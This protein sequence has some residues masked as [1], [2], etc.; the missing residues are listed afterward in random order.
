MQSIGIVF[1]QKEMCLVSLREGLSKV[2]LD[3]YNIVPFLD[4][5]EEDKESAI[6]SNLE[7]FL[8]TR[9]SARDNIFIALPRDTALIRFINLPIA[10]EENLRQSI[11]YELDRHTPFSADEAYFDYHV[12]KRIPESGLL[13]IMLVTIKKDQLDYYIQ[14]L[15]KIKIKPRNIEITTTALLNAFQDS[16]SPEEKLIDLNWL[17]KNKTLKEKYLKSL[18]KKY[19]KIAEFFKEQPEE[20]KHPSMG[21]LV[22]YL[23]DDKYELNLIDKNTLYYSK[24]F[25]TA[26]EVS[27][28]H[29][30]EIY[31][32]G[33][34]STLHLPFD[35]DSKKETEFILSGRKMEKGYTEN[36]P[37]NIKGFFSIINKFGITPASNSAGVNEVVLPLLSVPIGLALKGLKNVALDVNLVPLNQRLKKKRSKKKLVISAIPFI[38][39]ILIAA[40]ISNNINK[41]ERYEAALDKELKGYKL[42]AKNIDRLQSEISK[43]EQ[44]SSTIKN[45][46]ESSISKLTFLEELTLLMPMDGWLS[47]FSY[48][49]SDNKIK[50]SGYAVSASKLIPI[51]EESKLFENVKFTSPITQDKRSGKEK[52]RIEMT[53]SSEKK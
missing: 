35:K 29:F 20:K 44:S 26:K 41:A 53:V 12:I 17:K 3:G 30:Q 49:V 15:K 9:K 28:K 11:E 18:I 22:E 38:I 19:P 8:K 40:L 24:V 36:A 5:K 31:D 13:Y 46:K 42:K 10:V 32:K 16:I 6:L 7:R 39:L 34:E 1:K 52:F 43:I 48:K 37:E 47:D 27:E 33:L 14:L 45:I 51:F 21:I 4:L 23:N 25:H 50:L 2:Y